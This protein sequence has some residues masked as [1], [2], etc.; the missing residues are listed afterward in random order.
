MPDYRESR[1]NTNGGQIKNH[2]MN[3]GY[4]YQ[5]N[6]YSQRNVDRPYNYNQEYTYTSGNTVRKVQPSYVPPVKEPKKAAR[7]KRYVRPKQLADQGVMTG[8]YVAFLSAISI[9][10]L[11]T[12]YQYLSISSVVS[13][14]SSEATALQKNVSNLKMDNDATLGI[15][16]QTVNME[17]VKFRAQELGMEFMENEQVV[18]YKTST[19]D[20]MKQYNEIPSNGV[21]AQYERAYE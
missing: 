12:S 5:S 17:S 18:N 1:S 3:Q 4:V 14:K 15:V 19:E 16:N 13:S 6:G 11:F 7:R 2:T 21:V 9:I 10:V 8:A 20:M